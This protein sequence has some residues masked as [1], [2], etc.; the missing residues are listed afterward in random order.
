MDH[1]PPA[2]QQDQATYYVALAEQARREMFGPKRCE[3][4]ER[5]TREYNNIQLALR[6]LSD[7][8]EA[9][10]GLRLA[11]GLREFWLSGSQIDTGRHWLEIFL[12]QPQMAIPSKRRAQGLDD[13]ASLAFW[14]NDKET[15]RSLTLESLAIRRQLDDQQGVAVSLIHAGNFARLFERD[16]SAARAYYEESESILRELYGEQGLATIYIVQGNLALDE[17]EYLAAGRLLRQSLEMLRKEEAIWGI[18]FV[19]DS[20]AGVAAHQGQPQRALQL[21]AAGEALRASAGITHPPVTQ[22]WVEAILQPAKQALDPETVE[23]AWSKGQALT[24][25]EAVAY[26]LAEPD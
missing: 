2:N 3:W 17:G 9:E 16:F 21:A 8:G 23:A 13:L 24:W 14:Q 11:V 10:Q 20:L 19:L 18:N 5:L 15:V 26:A 6:W 25:Q 12:A 1:S 22:R 4:L 7:R